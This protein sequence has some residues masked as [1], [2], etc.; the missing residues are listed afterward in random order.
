MTAKVI[1]GNERPVT[2]ASKS[3]CRQV[4]MLLPELLRLRSQ[5]VDLSA[6]LALAEYER[7]AM[8]QLALVAL[9]VLAMGC[10]AHIWRVL[11]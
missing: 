10:V 6:K 5:V 9:T 4:S 7:D 8:R 3:T 11:A 1:T 2:P